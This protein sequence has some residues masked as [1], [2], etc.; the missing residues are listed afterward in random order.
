MCGQHADGHASLRSG[1]VGLPLCAISYA[2]LKFLSKK[3][4]SGT[5]WALYF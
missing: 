3:F 4:P 2:K 5:G 1:R